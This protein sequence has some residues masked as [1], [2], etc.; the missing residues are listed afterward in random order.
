MIV[1]YA[2]PFHFSPMEN[3]I[4]QDEEWMILSQP[5]SHFSNETERLIQLEHPA[6]TEQF[7][8]YGFISKENNAYVFASVVTA[9]SII[10]GDPLEIDMMIL[11]LEEYIVAKECSNGETIYLIGHHYEP[12]LKKVAD[13]YHVMIHI[14]TLDK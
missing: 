14:F 12:L 7:S 11:Q 4:E 10:D 13:T 2:V 9:F 8:D 5:P 1:R 3:V 6:L